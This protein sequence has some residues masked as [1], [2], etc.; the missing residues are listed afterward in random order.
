MYWF[1]NKIKG[2]YDS[3]PS[4]QLLPNFDEYIVGYKDRS[5]LVN[6]ISNNK[7]ELNEFIFNPTIILNGEIVGTWKRTFKEN[8]IK[9]LLNQFKSLNNEENRAIK[10]SA[11]S[12]GNSIR[13]HV[14]C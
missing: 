6:G 1:S 3:Y 4:S 9:I 10:E 13:M 2:I 11:A 8:K 12:Y 5:H 14:I 7:M